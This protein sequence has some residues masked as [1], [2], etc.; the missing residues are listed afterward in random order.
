MASWSEITAY[1]VTQGPGGNTVFNI[2]SHSTLITP[3]QNPPVSSDGQTVPGQF[4]INLYQSSVVPTQLGA[5]WNILGIG[6]STLFCPGGFGSG[7]NNTDDIVSYVN[8]NSLVPSV[9]GRTIVAVDADS[10]STTG[11][12]PLTGLQVLIDDWFLPSY[13]ELKTAL[14]RVGPGAPGNT[15]GGVPLDNIAEFNITNYPIYWTSSNWNGPSPPTSSYSYNVAKAI[16]VTV[17]NFPFIPNNTNNPKTW[18]CHTYNAKYIR[19]FKAYPEEER[20]LYNYRDCVMDPSQTHAAF[21]GSWYPNYIRGTFHPGSAGSSGCVSEQK[22][23]SFLPHDGLYWQHPTLNPTGNLTVE[24]S[25]QSFN[26][27]KQG[28]VNCEGHDGIIGMNWFKFFP[29]QYDAMG[30]KYVPSDFNRVTG[31]PWTITIWDCEGIF[32]GKW[33]Y[34]NLEQYDNSGNALLSPN[35]YQTNIGFGRAIKLMFSGVT[36]LAGPTDQFGNY[37]EPVVNYGGGWTGIKSHNA[38]YALNAGIAPVDSLGTPGK[39]LGQHYRVHPLY[40]GQ[41]TWNTNSGA[42][43]KLESGMMQKARQLQVSGMPAPNNILGGLMYPEFA[44]IDDFNDIYGNDSPVI[45]VAKGTPHPNMTK[46]LGLVGRTRGRARPLYDPSSVG[47]H[48]PNLTHLFHTFNGNWKKEVHGSTSPG[49]RINQSR[50]HNHHGPAFSLCEPGY[51]G[52]SSVNWEDAHR[53]NLNTSFMFGTQ[54][55]HGTQSIYNYTGTGGNQL[56]DFEDTVEAGQWWFGHFIH[57]WWCARELSWFDPSNPTCPI[58]VSNVAKFQNVWYPSFKI[59]LNARGFADFTGQL[60]Q[61]IHTFESLPGNQLSKVTINGSPIFPEFNAGRHGD[62]LRDKWMVKDPS[63]FDGYSLGNP[64]P[65]TIELSEQHLWG[66]VGSFDAEIIM[67]PRPAWF[68]D[69]TNHYSWEDGNMQYDV[70]V[71]PFVVVWIRGTNWADFVG[72]LNPYW[73]TSN[74]GGNIRLKYGDY[75]RKGQHWDNPSV[76]LGITYSDGAGITSSTFF[77]GAIECFLILCTLG[78]PLNP[79]IGYL[80]LNDPLFE[81]DKTWIDPTLPLI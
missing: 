51:W 66:G 25:Q 21:Q 62:Y 72:M 19:R 75:L 15:M 58:P 12:N 54:H 40:E 20:R 76:I 18:R 23:G 59:Y 57:P 28:G 1:T 13:R 47:I 39:G 46:Q 64:L 26:L 2:Q 3:F 52:P 4:K 43:I 45:C 32:L 49:M 74:T 73:W 78:C 36:Q 69:W 67:A 50:G 79:N 81:C 77:D 55:A 27:T 8:T 10:F 33:K 44:R 42:F 68:G 14:N 80:S 48:G 71:S 16:D 38:L 17:P 31:G 9:P 70:E 5:E 63:A 24:Q 56:S 11:I 35:N 34:D 37:S 41:Y 60:P 65:T 6:G 22:D 30:F 61:H 29:H 53:T 7:K